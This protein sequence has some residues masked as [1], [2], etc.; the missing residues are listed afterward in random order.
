MEIWKDC[1]G[2]E[3][4]YQVS[5]LGRI[6]SVKRQ[7]YLKGSYDKDGYIKL[8]LIAKN[9]KIKYERAHRLIALSF[10]ENPNSYTVVNHINGIKDDNRATNLEWTDV[11]ENTKHAYDNNLG[12]MKEIQKM[13]TEAAKLKNTKTYLIYKNGELIAEGYGILNTAE[14]AGCNEKTVRNCLR[15]NRTTRNGYSFAVKGGDANAENKPN[16]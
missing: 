16:T 15:E 12:G 13:A 4:L 8:T 1:K 11:K 9:G 6:W 5:D 3:G 2:Y 10:I 7:C 14:I